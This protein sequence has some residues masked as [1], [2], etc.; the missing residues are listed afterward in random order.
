ML[1]R[2]VK[3]LPKIADFYGTWEAQKLIITERLKYSLEDVIRQKR[4]S[5]ID[6]ERV[7]LNVAFGIQSLHRRGITYRDLSS[8]NVMV[9]SAD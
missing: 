9:K 1:Y 8:K 5:S 7:A 4:L 6:L 3:D 2:N